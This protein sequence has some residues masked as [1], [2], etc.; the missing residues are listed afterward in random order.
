MTAEQ[1]KRMS[2]SLFL[3][4]KAIFQENKDTIKALSERDYVLPLHS[5]FQAQKIRAF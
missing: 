5:S 2:Y 4:S 3:T 1:Q